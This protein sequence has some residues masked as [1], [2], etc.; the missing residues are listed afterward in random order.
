[1]SAELFESLEDLH[2]Y[3]NALES[4]TYTVCERIVMGS[5]VVFWVG[6]DSKNPLICT[7]A[8]YLV[9]GNGKK[10]ALREPEARNV[11]HS[12]RHVWSAV[13]SEA[14]HSGQDYKLEVSNHEILLFTA[15][16]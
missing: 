6:Y 11:N 4:G 7:G 2:I 14:P 9:N 8:C 13:C 10:L 3:R 12:T 16:K 1:M 15:P 5:N